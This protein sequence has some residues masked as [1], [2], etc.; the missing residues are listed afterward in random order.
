[1]S[2]TLTRATSKAAF[3]HIMDN[4]LQ[5]RS[6]FT[7]TDTIVDNLTYSEPDPN[8]KTTHRLKKGEMGILKSFIYYIYNR[9]ESENPIGDKWT[10]ITM[11]DFD[12]FRSNL[13]YTTSFGSLSTLKQTP[14]L[15]TLSSSSTPYSGQSHVDIINRDIKHGTSVF[16]TLKNGQFNDQWK[17]SFGN[18]ARAQ[19]VSAVLDATYSPSSPTDAAL[20]QE[21]PKYLYDVLEAKVETAKGK[22]IN[23]KYESMYDAQH[24]ELIAPHD[25]DNPPDPP[26]ST[27]NITTKRDSNC[28]KLHTLFEWLNTECIEKTFEPTTQYARLTTDI[29]ALF[30]FNFCSYSKESL[31]H[32]VGISKHCG[33]ALTYK[34]LTSDTEHIIYHSLLRPVTPTDANLRAGMFEGEQGTHN[35]NPIIKSRH[36][37]DIMEDSKPT[38]AAASASPPPVINPEDLIGHSFLMDK[39]EDDQ[40]Y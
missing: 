26:P 37:F 27:T 25:A 40:Q 32:I 19:D 7:L 39:Q 9:N 10:A 17:V 6:L 21:K 28:D 5:Y 34:I 36:D 23:R 11:A 33:H 38:D 16:P 22:L 18:Q 30:S 2:P 15:I 31:G 35:G 24:A 13:A 14:V 1:M 8:V 12:Q 3:T 20:F 4:A 29:S